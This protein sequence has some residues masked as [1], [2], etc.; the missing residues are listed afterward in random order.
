MRI[1]EFILRWFDVPRDLAKIK[2][3]QRALYERQNDI[4]ADLTALNS[5]ANDIQSVIG[6][7]IALL[8]TLAS[9]PTPPDQ[10]AE[11]D[12]VTAKLQA[13]R[14]ALAAAVR[15]DTPSTPATPPSAPPQEPPTLDSPVHPSA[16]T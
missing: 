8:N 15:Q 10:Q 4:M 13:G 16:G 5:V 6:Q 3:T 12:A 14:D 7:A 1:I 9:T 2:H 11:I